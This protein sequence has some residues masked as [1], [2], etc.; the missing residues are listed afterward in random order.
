MHAN[1][2]HDEW[3]RP[4]LVAVY[5]TTSTGSRWNSLCNVAPYAM[6]VG[7]DD[8]DE[9]TK[10]G[11]ILRRARAPAVQIPATT[12]VRA[13]SATTRAGGRR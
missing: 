12:K 6:R 2:G 5:P 13:A 8:E 3:T 10:A 9:N 11:C 4:E 7:H 1:R